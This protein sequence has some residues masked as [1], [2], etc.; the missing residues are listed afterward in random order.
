MQAFPSTKKEW[1]ALTLFPFKAYVVVVLPFYFLF[2]IFCPQP[3]TIYFGN[4]TTVW[5][6]T[7]EEFLTGFVLCGPLLMLG[8]IIQLCA[9]DAKSASRT[10]MF[11]IVPFGVF[12]FLLFIGAIQHVL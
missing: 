10:L 11:A 8:L 5:N 7:A 2:N 9:R 6:H 1:I 4:N 3:L 12:C